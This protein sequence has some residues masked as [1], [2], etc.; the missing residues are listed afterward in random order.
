M[1][2]SAGWIRGIEPENQILPFT[3]TLA[4]LH[5]NTFVFLDFDGNQIATLVLDLKE[6][7]I[8]I[9][10]LVLYPDGST[11]EGLIGE[12]ASEVRAMVWSPKLA[13]KL[14][15]RTDSMPWSLDQD[16]KKVPT[17]LLVRSGDTTMSCAQI[18]HSCCDPCK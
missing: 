9:T 6:K 7:I 8:G 11:W 15:G 14:Q 3:T 16:W 17:A 4:S 18:E 12:N 2:G 1:H 5:D 10:S 13:E